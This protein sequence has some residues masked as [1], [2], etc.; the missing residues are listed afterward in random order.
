[1]MQEM[2]KSVP[3]SDLSTNN[4][5]TEIYQGMLDSEYAK[6]AARTNGVGLADLIIAYLDSGQYTH[7][8]SAPPAVSRG[9]TGGTNEGR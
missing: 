1:M 2:R 8:S 7:G 4:K 5:A 6:T 9:S 3:E